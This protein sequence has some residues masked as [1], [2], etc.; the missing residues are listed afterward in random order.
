MFYVHHLKF[1]PF[2][3]SAPHVTGAAGLLWR[4]CPDCSK[5]DVESCLLTTALDVGAPGRDVYYGEGILD[6]A[7]AM[8]CMSSKD[9][10]FNPESAI[11]VTTDAPTESPS[12]APTS[13][14][15]DKPTPSPTMTPTK[16]PTLAPT[17]NVCLE[18]CDEKKKFCFFRA[19]TICGD[20]ESSCFS[21]CDTAIA[22]QYFDAAYLDECKSSWCIVDF[23][24][25]ISV[26]EAECNED[27]S[28]CQQSC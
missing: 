21:M 27:D 24:A 23:Q 22:G 19:Q 12:A 15:T 10:C 8:T 11:V 17:E 2:L 28:V 16:T 7:S 6:T 26:K 5:D 9:C 20:E 3:I 4:S 14:P 18:R 13:N 25:C 1:I